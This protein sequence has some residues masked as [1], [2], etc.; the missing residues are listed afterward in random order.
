[1]G[2]KLIFWDAHFTKLYMPTK[3]GHIPKHIIL[4][5][6]MLKVNRW[7]STNLRWWNLVIQNVLIFFMGMYTFIRQAYPHHIS[8]KYAIIQVLLRKIFSKMWD[9]L[10][11]GV[12][13]ILP[14]C[15][16]AKSGHFSYFS[17][18][19]FNNLP[20]Q[21]IIQEQYKNTELK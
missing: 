13:G 15:Y 19:F 16:P 9:S 3:N 6:T 21:F 17:Y 8:F 11:V 7:K 10:K 12:R 2:S 1:M 20:G 4:S 5:S 18:F 14:L